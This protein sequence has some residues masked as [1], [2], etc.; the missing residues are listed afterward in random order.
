MVTDGKYRLENYT[1]GELIESSEGTNFVAL[2]STIVMSVVVRKIVFERR[3][4][5]RSNERECPCCG[6]I[7]NQLVQ[8]SMRWYVIGRHLINDSHFNFLTAESYFVLFK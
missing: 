1:T 7:V 8:N 6:E 4:L 2:G 3:K 5:L